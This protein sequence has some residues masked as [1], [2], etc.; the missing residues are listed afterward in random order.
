M[1]KNITVETN[2]Q[3]NPNL[4]LTV[5]GMVEK[6][7]TIIPKNVILRGFIGDQLKTTVKIIPEE[8]YPFKIIESKAI[9][10][11][12]IRFELEEHKLSKGMEYVLTVENLKKDEGRYIDNISL[13]T[14]SKIRPLIR[15]SVNGSIRARQPNIKK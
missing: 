11:K 12:N 9:N 3:K 1:N 13:E 14:D 15:I 4:N 6:F 2:D 8:K 10:G 7:V 5:F